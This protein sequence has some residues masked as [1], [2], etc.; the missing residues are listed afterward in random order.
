MKKF[1]KIGALVLAMMM[2][3]AM[4]VPVFA[5]DTTTDGTGSLDSSPA[6]P[7]IRT[8]SSNTLTLNK[9]II[10]FNPETVD[11]YEPNI[12]FSYTIEAVNVTDG[13]AT[14][15]DKDNHVAVVNDGVA[16]GLS[17]TTTPVFADTNLVTGV[18]NKG[19][20]VEKDLV[21]TIDPTAFTHAGVYRYK[22]TDTTAVATLNTVGITRGADYNTI[23]YIDLYVKNDTTNPGQFIVTNA[24]V[25]SATTMTDPTTGQVTT[26]T[27]K[28]TGF[29]ESPQA[30]S[31][32]TDDTV[33]DHYYTYNLKVQKSITGALAD[34]THKFPF[35][36]SFTGIKADK[37]TKSLNGATPAADTVTSGSYGSSDVTA[38]NAQLADGEYIT[39]Y[40]IPY[41]AQATVTEYNDTFD[42]YN[43]TATGSGSS[44]TISLSSTPLQPND[45]TSTAQVANILIN[46]GTAHTATDST[47]KT[48]ATT[49]VT[50]TNNLVEISPTGVVLRVAPFVGIMGAGL[51]LLLIAK[52]FKKDEDEEDEVLETIPQHN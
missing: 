34:K 20:S 21:L 35:A 5:A 23:R 8:I 6:N 51:F 36:I 25:F 17:I 39:F 1:T 10:F 16:A 41:G 26:S 49:A 37:I 11:V 14:V 15:K 50:F 19:V 52:R 33:A 40:G 7:A 43:A 13:S 47:Q 31:D 12:T 28:T 46:A 38:P 44:S 29:N 18:T 4:S 27:E 24:V 32:W 48:T 42:L 45:S 3:L 2:I 30:D 22:L 9:T